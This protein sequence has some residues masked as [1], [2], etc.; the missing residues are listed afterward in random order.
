MDDDRVS[1][2]AGG[3]DTHTKHRDVAGSGSR[4]GQDQQQISPPQFFLAQC[5]DVD[6]SE[7]GCWRTGRAEMEREHAVMKHREPVM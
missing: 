3:R 5:R 7:R 6:P 4:T 2:G 1:F